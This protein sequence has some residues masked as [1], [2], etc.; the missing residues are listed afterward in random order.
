MFEEMW[1][2]ALYLRTLPFMDWAI[3]VIVLLSGVK[4]A[5]DLFV[6]AVFKVDLLLASLERNES[7]ATL[8]QCLFD[9]QLRPL[10]CTVCP[11]CICLC[12]PCS[13]EP[14]VV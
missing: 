1:A 11:L 9:K 13:L 5:T 12:Q 2:S 4:T 10:V 6:F 3:T 8:Y 7:V 14:A